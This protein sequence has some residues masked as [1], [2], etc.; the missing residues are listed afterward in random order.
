MR[1]SR[2]IL[3]QIR[4]ALLIAFFFSGW[5]NILMLATPLYTLQ[6]FE[7]VVP[8]GSIETLIVL[9]VITAGA[10][11]ALALLESARD[12]ILLRSGLWL[13]HELGQHILENGLKIGRSPVELK[14]DARALDQFRAYLTSPAITPLF[15]APFVPLFLVLLTA[16]HPVIGIVATVAAVILLV[17]TYVK[18]RLT[19]RLNV[20]GTQAYERA[21]RWWM[22]VASTGQLAGALGLCSGA[23]AQWES[24]NRSH[25]A[26]A[27]S[28][29]KREKFVKVFART[30]RIGSQIA[31][32]GFGAWL[33]IAG[34][35]SPGALI[36][37]AIMLARALGPLEQLVTAVGATQ[38]GWKA[39]AHLKAL[40]EDADLPRVDSDSDGPVGQV[41]LVGVTFHYPTRQVPA[42]RNINLDLKPGQCLGIV[43]PNGSGKSSLAK[44]IAGAVTPTVGAAD[45]DTLPIS[46]WQRVMVTPP[47]GYLP[48]EPALVEGT[49][50]ENIAR[51]SDVSQVSVAH[52]AMIAGVHDAL[53][54][55]P[56]GYDTP[57]G[58]D[59]SNLAL[60]ERRAVALAR[61]IHGNPKLIVLD[62]PEVG[63]DGAGLRRLVNVLASLK[64]TGVGLVIATQDPRLLALTD[65][66]AL[67][68]DGTLQS[69]TDSR[70]LSNQLKQPAKM[71]ANHNPAGHN[72]ASAK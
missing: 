58:P 53:H 21:H 42:L 17:C 26:T 14:A 67:L 7:N 61:A 62:E 12:V 43:G 66:I 32:Y 27:Y 15:D 28:R 3:R 8:M 70:E 60:S 65:N 18:H 31:L 10:I 45:L 48:D 40:P 13:D 33:V 49:V 68:A 59:G 9:T 19:K 55:L 23:T 47:I 39:Y 56:S 63:L 30:V 35:M 51:F 52:A 34:Q 54:A 41:K 37:S 16:M 57:V 11:L 44:I 25:I 46:K 2:R 4:R 71:A 6:V 36:A 24:Y 20:E 22:T 29:G 1:T 38:S 69:L 64:D 50:H 5:I 72:L